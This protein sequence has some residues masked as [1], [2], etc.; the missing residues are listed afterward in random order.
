[1]TTNVETV[2]LKDN[3]YEVAVKMRDHNVGI[4]PVVDEAN[5]VIGLITDRDIVIRGLAEKREGSASVEQVMSNSLVVGRPD[6]TVKEASQ[7]MADNQ[8]RRLPVTENGKLVGIVAMA[9][10]ARE[11]EFI[12]QSGQVISEISETTGEHR[13]EQ[14]RNIQ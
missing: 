9:D 4:I 5:H 8:I 12:S 6:M 3:V 1:M 13:S 14:P 10:I 7:L 11:E 2:T